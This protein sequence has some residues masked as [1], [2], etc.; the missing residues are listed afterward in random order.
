MSI[1][2]VMFFFNIITINMPMKL[3]FILPKFSEF[4]QSDFYAENLRQCGGV[5][6]PVGSPAILLSQAGL[7]N[8]RLPSGK[9]LSV[10]DD[11]HDLFIDG[12]PIGSLS[13]PFGA[14]LPEGPGDDCIILTTD[15]APEWIIDGKLRG[16]FS[17]LN[18]DV[19]LSAV[20]ETILEQSVEPIKLSGSYPRASGTLTAPDTLK[21]AQLHRNALST[22]ENS[23]DAP[24]S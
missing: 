11:R 12:A 6:K 24:R 7:R 21:A 2:F 8:F 17:P 22:L 18:S 14:L 4:S 16:K 13:S 9:I 1:I 10:G 19:T 23:A 15:S 20:N 3:D 5:L